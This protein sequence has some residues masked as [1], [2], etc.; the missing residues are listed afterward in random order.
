MLEEPGKLPTRGGYRSRRRR[1]KRNS[2]LSI[3]GHGRTWALNEPVGLPSTQHTDHDALDEQR[4]LLQIHP[5]RL[6][7]AVLR[8][9]P[10]DGAFLAIALDGDLVL[11]TR[12][13]DLTAAHLRRTVD[14]NQVPIENAGILH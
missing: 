8:Q 7:V 4:L 5:D 9:Q 10:H 12:Y 14:G 3:A 2:M 6:E 11:Q 13:D 1:S